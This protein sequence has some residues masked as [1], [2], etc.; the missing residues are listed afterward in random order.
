V[1]NPWE[2]NSSSLDKQSPECYGNRNFIPA[3][4]KSHH[5]SISSVMSVQLCHPILCL[6]DHFNIT[7]HPR[8]HRPSCYIPS[9]F[10][11]KTLCA[12]LPPV[13]YNS[14]RKLPS[15]RQWWNIELLEVETI[16][17]PVKS[18]HYTV[19]DY[20]CFKCQQIRSNVMYPN[21]IFVTIR[22]Q[23]SKIQYEKD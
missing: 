20:V 9:D 12:L 21:P 13:I 10:P 8:Q 22:F 14:K 11:T 18:K 17:Y 6:K 23:Y 4:T 7:I 19:S 5:F 1:Q 16:C 15:P 2:V 3:L